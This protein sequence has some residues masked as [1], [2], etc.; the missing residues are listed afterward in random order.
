[1]IE[2]AVWILAIYVI[3]IVAVLA[4]VL[5]FAIFQTIARAIYDGWTWK[6]DDH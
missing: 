3:A 1:M 4:G 2:I 5:L 6:K